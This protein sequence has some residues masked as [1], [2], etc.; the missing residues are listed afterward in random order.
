L[1]VAP[2]A[3]SF[4]KTIFAGSATCAA[5]NA[6]AKIF[7]PTN[8]CI[9]SATDNSAFVVTNCNANNATFQQYNSSASNGQSCLGSPVGT[10]ATV[11]PTA[12]N[13]DILNNQTVNVQ[14][15]CQT[16]SSTSTSTGATTARVTTTSTTG[17]RTS[18]TTTGSGS[19]TT[20]SAA[21]VFASAFVVVAAVFVA[22]F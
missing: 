19:S 13:I 4:I 10:A 16:S 18:T 21:T 8:V 20:S 1:T 3:G 17:N 11:L 5:A 12:C 9:P 14:Y 2:S 7:G 6:V 15:S 22:A